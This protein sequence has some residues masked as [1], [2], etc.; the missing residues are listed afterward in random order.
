MSC[1]ARQQDYCCRNK[2]NKIY[3][4][5]GYYYNDN[6]GSKKFDKNVPVLNIFVSYEPNDSKIIY[7]TKQFLSVTVYIISNN[8]L[9]KY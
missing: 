5:I 2:I 4:I 6:S 3:A 1:L 7:N 8:T 9:H